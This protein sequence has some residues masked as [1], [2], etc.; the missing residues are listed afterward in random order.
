MGVL[1][2]SSYRYDRR[3]DVCLNDAIVGAN[4]GP[5][6]GSAGTRDKA[7]CLVERT[8]RFERCACT[9]DQKNGDLAIIGLGGILDFSF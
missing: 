9:D 2:Q 1:G 7:L 3:C 4:N 6:V 8:R 5:V